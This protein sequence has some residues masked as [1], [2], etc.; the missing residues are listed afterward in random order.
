MYIGFA[1]YHCPRPKKNNPTDICYT[2]N[3]PTYNS[4]TVVCN[5]QLPARVGRYLWHFK[6]IHVTMYRCSLKE[7]RFSLFYLLK[8]DG[9]FSWE[10]SGS[11]IECLTRDRGAAG[12]SLTGT[13]LCPW[14]K[15]INPRLLL[16]QPRK[17]LPYITERL[18][19]GRKES[20]QTNKR[21]LLPRPIFLFWFS[22]VL[23]FC[24]YYFT[25]L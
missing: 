2:T 11:V 8:K 7:I 22:S 23:T 13:A 12:L 10:R 20:N 25:N 24:V 16:V 3:S 9:N 15:H 21:P 6:I 1:G 19:M 5:W 14:A 17:T 18:L 4:F